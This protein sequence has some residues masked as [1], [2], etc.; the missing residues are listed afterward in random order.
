M[1]PVSYSVQYAEKRSRLTTFFRYFLAIPVFIVA[2]FW[3]IGAYLGVIVAWFALLFTARY[4]E[5][6]YNFEVKAIRML[7]RSSAYLYLLT[8][9]YPSFGGDDDPDY[10][11]RVEIA[12][13]QEQYSRAKTFF[14][15]FLAIPVWIMLYLY[16]IVVSFVSFV[17]WV[18]IVVTGKQ[19]RGLQDL[20]VMASSYHTKA[21]AYMFLLTERY[22]PVTDRT[23]LQ[24]PEQPATIGG[25]SG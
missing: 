25:L 16:G 9:K 14:R 6:I 18:V 10:P 5:G 7:Q 3:A 8:D 21:F 11:V 1:Y 20:L 19:P 24:P 15:Y 17:S 23:E 13:P 2:F 22:P 12:A 4:P